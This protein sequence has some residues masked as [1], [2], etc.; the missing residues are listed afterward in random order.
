MASTMISCSP[1][2]NPRFKIGSPY[3][4]EGVQY[5]P[6][7]MPAYKEEGLASWYGDDFH[8][9][10]TANGELF[11]KTR[12]TGA[13]KTLPLPSIVDVTNLE[14]GKKVKIRIND[15]GPFVKGRIV[16]VSEKA[17]KELGFF[18][19]GS[20]KVMVELDREASIKA[21]DSIPVSREI[22][23]LIVN[24]YASQS[25]K[26]SA[27]VVKPTLQK[28]EGSTSS[29][30]EIQQPAQPA[31]VTSTTITNTPSSQPSQPLA[32][33]QNQKPKSLRIAE[34]LGKTTATVTQPATTQTPAATPGERFVQIGSFKNK[35]EAESVVAK[36]TD[37]SN[38]RIEEAVVNG[39]T[40]YRVKIGGY[41]SGTETESALAS[42]KAKGFKDA[43]ITK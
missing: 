38:S 33:E 39:Q 36:L 22:R 4:A 37:F 43:F 40:Y 23:E 15:R 35:T 13:H 6:K 42:L 1:K 24:Q 2:P 26:E 12:M 11:D 25:S 19:Q 27:E 7:I 8:S 21:L 28:S 29:P 31:Q 10:L 9:K 41:V 20:A 3:S 17:A 32:A 34:A 30:E 14:N 16:D 18:G 5:T